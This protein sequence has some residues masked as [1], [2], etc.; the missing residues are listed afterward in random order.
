LV[1]L[2]CI[3]KTPSNITIKVSFDSLAHANAWQILTRH[4]WH[5]NSVCN[6]LGA[7]S[8]LILICSFS[9]LNIQFLMFI[10]WKYVTT[11]KINRKAKEKLNK[12]KKFLLLFHVTTWEH[13]AGKNLW[14][15]LSCLSLR[16]FSL[17]FHAQTEAL[18]N[19]L[20]SNCMLYC[21]TGLKLQSN[22]SLQH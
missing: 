4:V 5:N 16:F 8:E 1:C 11:G 9:H 15:L 20:E 7:S 13:F 2:L 14:S 6:K 18:L 3:F 10:Q 17:P 19:N 21:S 12:L 22:W